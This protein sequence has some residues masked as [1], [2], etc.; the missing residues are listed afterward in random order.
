[1]SERFNLPQRRLRL[2]FFGTPDIAATCLD[3]LLEAD[4]DDVALV[5]CQ[6]DRPKG[7]GRAR[8]LPPVKER[9]LQADLPVEQTRKLKDGVLAARLREQSIDLGVVVAYGRILP[10]DLFTA[11]RFETLNVH[12]SLLPRHRGASP[13]QH[14]ILEG[15]AETGVT[16]MK[17]SEG[18]DEG[19]MLLQRRLAI[20]DMTGGQLFEAVAAL[21]A[22]TLVEGLAQAKEEGLEVRAQDDRAASYAGMLKKEDGQLDLSAPAE[23]LARR[24]RAFDPWPG[25]VLAAPTGSLKVWAAQAHPLPGPAQPGEL[26]GPAFIGC[27]EGA[28]ELL[29]VQPP[30]KR[31]MSIGDFLRGRGK[32]WTPGETRFDFSRSDR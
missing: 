5:V 23:A 3:A 26:L 8:A 11:P 24:I 2:A 9:A 7:R 19:P 18:M 4:E 30:G 12:A 20:G 31:R 17:L 22:R 10:L 32:D 13:I 25:T 28:L 16:L 15:D 14:A 21:G 27:G 1:M 6:P 29:E